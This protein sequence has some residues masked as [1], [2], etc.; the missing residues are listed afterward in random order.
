MWDGD[1]KVQDGFGERGLLPGHKF[2]WRDLKIM[3]PSKSCQFVRTKAV[4]V[5]V[6][7]SIYSTITAAQL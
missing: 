5:M 6:R 3:T 1:W 7:I 4:V 2:L